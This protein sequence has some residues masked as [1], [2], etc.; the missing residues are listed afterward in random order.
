MN[1]YLTLSETESYLRKCARAVGLEWG[2]AE[3]AGKAARWLAAFGLP[4]PELAL[5]H[6]L[7]LRGQDYR[8]FV[9][10]VKSSPWLLEGEMLCPIITGAAVAKLM[11]RWLTPTNTPALEVGEGV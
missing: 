4:G 6:L 1:R 7:T 11:Q 3:E 5:S 8:R 10:D 2:I 9:P